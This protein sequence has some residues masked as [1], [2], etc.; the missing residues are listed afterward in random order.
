MDSSTAAARRSKEEEEGRRAVRD[1]RRTGPKE[2]AALPLLLASVRS[3]GWMKAK[4]KARI[5]RKKTKRSKITT[6]EKAVMMSK[7]KDKTPR[8]SL[9]SIEDVLRACVE[10]AFS[11]CVVFCVCLHVED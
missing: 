11:L 6:P 10:S 4:M 2:P 9:V 8:E 1:R 7:E 3:S 5:V